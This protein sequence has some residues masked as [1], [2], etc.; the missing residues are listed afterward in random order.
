MATDIEAIIPEGLM[1]HLATISLPA[2]VRIAWPNVNFT[3]DSNP[4]LR[5]LI[6]KNEP[7]QPRIR[8]GNEPIR[9]GIFQ[10]SVM[11]PQGQGEIAPNEITGQIRTHFARGTK[12]EQDGITIRIDREPSVGGSLQEEAWL[13]VP[14]L[15]NWIVYP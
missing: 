11:W 8:F 3:P 4:Y 9:L 13:R 7:V 2:G 15:I 5:V 10:V 14:I 12:I 6:F 1:A